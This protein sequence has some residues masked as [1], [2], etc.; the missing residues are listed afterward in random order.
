M[1]RL[2]LLLLLLLL[3]LLPHHQIQ[4]KSYPTSTPPDSTTWGYEQG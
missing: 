4:N 1:H 3:L 2:V